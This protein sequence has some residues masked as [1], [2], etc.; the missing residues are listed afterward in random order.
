MACFSAATDVVRGDDLLG[1][2][3]RQIVLQRLLG[4]PTP[5]YL[6]VP[7]VRAAGGDKLSKQTGAPPVDAAASGREPSMSAGDGPLI[8]SPLT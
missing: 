7:V 2:T 5:R 3:P 4:A 8:R 1:S 6:H